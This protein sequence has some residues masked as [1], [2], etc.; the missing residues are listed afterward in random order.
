[1]YDVGTEPDARF[2][3]ANER[4]LLAWIRTSFA[5]AAGGGGLLVVRDVLGPWSIGLSMISFALSLTMVVGAS[6]RWARTER[7]LRVKGVV[8]PPWL[9]LIVVAA[10]A[11]AM[12]VALVGAATFLL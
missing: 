2:T 10:V 7:T 11:A 6:V 4:T 1:M 8:P 9:A 3:L 12:V 5:F